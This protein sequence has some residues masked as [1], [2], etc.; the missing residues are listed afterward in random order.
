MLRRCPEASPKRRPSTNSSWSEIRSISPSCSTSPVM[1]SVLHKLT[2]ALKLKSTSPK[3]VS[4]RKVKRNKDSNNNNKMSSSRQSATHSF[5]IG[6]SSTEDIE[7]HNVK[8]LV[9]LDKNNNQTSERENEIE[10]TN[11]KDEDVKPVHRFSSRIN[12]LSNVI[13]GKDF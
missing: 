9:A 5:P 3:N 10:P 6:N 12:K 4:T 1:K 13:Y 11:D 7:I 2:A 8:S